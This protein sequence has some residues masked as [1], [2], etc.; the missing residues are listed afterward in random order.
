[1]KTKTASSQLKSL[2]S[3]PQGWKIPFLG[4]ETMY[5]LN[6]PQSSSESITTIT[7]P[8]RMRNH[9]KHLVK[10]MIGRDLYDMW[11]KTS[12][13]EGHRYAV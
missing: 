7:W 2:I 12:V 8:R 9:C 10:N 1:M 3:H 11:L 13:G 6:L 4:L 5:Y